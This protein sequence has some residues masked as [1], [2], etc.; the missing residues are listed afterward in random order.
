MNIV[1]HAAATATATT[2]ES[3]RTAKY[4][5]RVCSKT[6]SIIPKV[7]VQMKQSYR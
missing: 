1:L 6:E 5:M 2:S 7:S 3:G 4:R